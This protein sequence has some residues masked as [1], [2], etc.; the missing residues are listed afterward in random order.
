M[1]DEELR[2]IWEAIAGP[3]PRLITLVPYERELVSPAPRMGVY[4]RYSELAT[5]D[6][7]LQA[8]YLQA[9]TRNEPHSVLPKLAS[10][11]NALLV[12]SALS[13]KVHATFNRH[14]LREE[15]L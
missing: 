1:T 12:E 11:N 14:L 15:H 2:R 7:P 13:R 5:P 10:L 9:L 8:L 4:W 6:G 3:R